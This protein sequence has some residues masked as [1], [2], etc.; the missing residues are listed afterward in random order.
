MADLPTLDDLPLG[1]ELAL[2]GGRH[3][4][5]ELALAHAL[6]DPGEARVIAEVANALGPGAW[7]GR[8]A[9][10]ALVR[11]APDPRG[12]PEGDAERRSARC[13]FS[14]R[15]DHFVILH[16]Y[17]PYA[18]LYELGDPFAHAIMDLGTD[19]FPATDSYAR[20]AAIDAAPKAHLL[21]TG[22]RSGGGIN[23][24]R[25]H[26]ERQTLERIWAPQP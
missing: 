16:T 15:D 24:H 11:D 19:P 12:G 10:L 14:K 8:G 5:S 3:A 22:Q 18:V 2:D 23:V 26:P 1:A 17:Q 13:P 9:A 6:S 21:V 7:L 4:V 20:N 25:F